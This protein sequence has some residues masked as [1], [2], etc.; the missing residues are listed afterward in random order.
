MKE[1]TTTTTRPERETWELRERGIIPMRRYTP[2]PTQA[3]PGAEFGELAQEFERIGMSGAESRALLA[4]LFCG[5]GTASELA[6]HAKVPRPNMYACLESLTAQGLAQLLP[7]RGVATWAS[8]GPDAVI[9]RLRALQ[10]E[11]LEESDRRAEQARELL[12]KMLPEHPSAPAPYLRLLPDGAATS[13]EYGRLLGGATTELLMFTRPPYAGYTEAPNPAVMD[14][15]AR[16]VAAKV[17]Y[18][19]GHAGEDEHPLIHTVHDAYHAAG[20]EGRVVDVLPIKLVIFDRR[21][22]L[23]A[24][25]DP[26]LAAAGYPVFLLI[27]H[28]GAAEVLTEA[29]E[30]YWAR[31]RPYQTRVESEDQSAGEPVHESPLAGTTTELIGRRRR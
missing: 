6:V 31:S 12:N 20:A 7:D 4:L 1:L 30:Q 5:T 25:T 18:E 24:M 28:P 29:F 10:R 13:R 3:A 2:K 27:E 9:D 14:A 8:I 21:V 17:L 22:V 16:G 19:A 23:M 15:L 26:I 11:R